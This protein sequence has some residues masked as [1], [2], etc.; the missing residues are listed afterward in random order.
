VLEYVWKRV[1][2]DGMQSHHRSFF[3]STMQLSRS[4]AIAVASLITHFV[5]RSQ[6]HYTPVAVHC[7]CTFGVSLDNISVGG[8]GDIHTIEHSETAGSTHW[9]VEFSLIS[10]WYLQCHIIGIFRYLRACCGARQSSVLAAGSVLGVRAEPLVRPS[11]STP[12]SRHG[13]AGH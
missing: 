12:S 1:Q 13:R 7:H 3:G 6:V 5:H 4:V 10:V 11:I 8:G 9:W 2:H